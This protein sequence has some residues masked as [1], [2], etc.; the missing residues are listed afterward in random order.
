M[1]YS[2]NYS[3]KINLNDFDEIIIKYEDQN[4]ELIDFLEEHQAQEIVLL[5]ENVIQFI[6]E[7]HWRLINAIYEE[8]QNFS[9][10]L[11]ALHKF[12]EFSTEELRAVGELKMPW[13]TGKLVS[14]FDQLNY[15]LSIGASQVYIVED[16]GFDLQRAKR[17]CS[18]RH[19]KIRV[20]PNVAQSSVHMTPALKKF[21]IRPEDLQ[22]YSDVVDIVEFWGPTDRQA[23]LRR[24]YDKGRWPGDLNDLILDLNY[25]ID[26]HR[27]LAQFGE[28]RKT[29]GRKCMKG[30]SCAICEKISDIAQKLK[31]AHIQV[32]H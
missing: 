17:V 11:H 7:E 20:F 15:L 27:I 3:N 6:E 5:V 12:T 22:L 2:V 29:C 4:Q 19:A 13:F 23:I 1:K 31:S 16:L 32:K 14:T 18:S 21:F 30:S 28:V 25:S 26:S 10:C 24:I 9:V 8:H